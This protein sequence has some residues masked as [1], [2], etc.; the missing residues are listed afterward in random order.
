MGWIAETSR[1]L[2]TLLMNAPLIMTSSKPQARNA[3]NTNSFTIAFLSNGETGR[4]TST[5]TIHIRVETKRSPK[6]LLAEIIDLESMR[7]MIQLTVRPESNAL[8]I[9]TMI[10]ARDSLS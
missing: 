7:R 6:N 10:R 4:L 2:R 5:G 8:R 9:V 1:L 3:P